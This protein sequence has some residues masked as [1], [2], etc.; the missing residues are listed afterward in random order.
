MSAQ[1]GIILGIL[2]SL[3]LPVLSQ[4]SKPKNML[5]ADTQTFHF[6]YSF[7]VNI[8]G[9]TAIP[10]DGYHLDLIQNPGININLITDYRLGKFLDIRFLPGIQF[11]SR[12]LTVT[13][14]LSPDSTQSWG[15]ESVYVDL[16]ILLKYRSLRVNNYAPYLIAGINPRFDLVRSETKNPFQPSI[17]VLKS[18][19]FYIE[20][21]VG[22]D[23]YLSMVKVAME[24]KFAVGMRDVF[25]APGDDKRFH[26]YNSG[27]SSIYSR[28][29]I[30]V[31]HVE[32]SR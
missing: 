19:D 10:K 8:A 6:G 26:I 22:V 23:F 3:S 17:S 25:L 7:G 12:D 1:K 20:L 27:V 31:F 13:N 28:M 11:A 21:G 4:K 15:I 14:K 29:V 18:F 9:F 24:L 16:P 2:L 30:L 32:Q 5:M